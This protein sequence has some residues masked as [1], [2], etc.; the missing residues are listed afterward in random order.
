MHDNIPATLIADSMAGA[1]FGLHR[2]KTFT[3]GIGRRTSNDLDGEGFSEGHPRDITPSGNPTTRG[4]DNKGLAA[5]IVGADRVAAN[6]DTAN[7]VGTYSLAILAKH[8]GVPFVVAAPRS[9]IDMQTLSG[10]EIV[11]E[12]RP[13]HELGRVAGMLIDPEPKIPERGNTLSTSTTSIIP[14]DTTAATTHHSTVTSGTTAAGTTTDMDTATTSSA[15]ENPAGAVGAS[16]LAT[17]A[18]TNHTKAHPGSAGDLDHAPEHP[19]VLEEQARSHGRGG[20]QAQKTV[21]VAVAAPGID[22]WNPAFDV[23]PAALIDAI[24]TEVGVVEKGP[25]GV[26]DLETLF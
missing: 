4:A 24:V 26:F 23:T 18:A 25:D 15:A 16:S 21:A 2:P 17:T 5:V 7:K 20:V 3:P 10:E 1:L 12:E 22:V 11:I 14:T 9:S 8:H 6:G 13:A 19:G